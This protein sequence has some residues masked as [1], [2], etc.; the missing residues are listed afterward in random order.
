MIFFAEEGPGRVSSVVCQLSGGK[1]PT[2]KPIPL[3]PLCLLRLPRAGR[4]PQHPRAGQG[5][6]GAILPHGRGTFANVGCRGSL[7]G[8]PRRLRRGRP[9]EVRCYG[10]CFVEL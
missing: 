10:F 4:S 8:W 5:F 2:E 6:E 1:P 7:S 3:P 9:E